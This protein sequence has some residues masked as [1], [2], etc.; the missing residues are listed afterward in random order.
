MLPKITLRQVWAGYKNCLKDFDYIKDGCDD[1]KYFFM[2]S[3][4]LGLIIKKYYF[5]Y[6]KTNLTKAYLASLVKSQENQLLNQFSHKSE[7]Y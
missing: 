5:L 6:Y 2:S 3:I 7:N 4:S 1:I